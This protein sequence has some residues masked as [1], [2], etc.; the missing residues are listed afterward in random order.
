[1]LPLGCPLVTV[2]RDQLLAG[3]AVALRGP[4]AAG[5]VRDA[6][7]EL[8]ASLQDDTARVL[9]Y[10]AADAFAGGGREGLRAALERAWDAILEVAAEW[11]SAEAD[12]NG[13]RKIVLIAPR[14]GAGPFVAAAAGGL[15]NLARTLSVEW[16]RFAVSTTV[17]VPADDDQP[18]AELVCFLAS[19][20][21][22]YFS[23]CRFDLGGV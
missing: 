16:A 9:V 13:A 22:D 12:A 4:S 6:L 7:T 20:A 2:L 17:I 15:E 8:G 18:V 11:A 21:G 14:R 23:G 3:R 19:T 1:M 10:D 5:A